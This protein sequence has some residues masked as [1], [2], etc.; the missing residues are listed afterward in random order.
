MIST[1]A[2]TDTLK[3]TQAIWAAAHQLGLPIA[4]WRLPNTQLVQG[5]VDLSGKP[6]QTIVDLEELPAGFVVSPF[7]NPDTRQSLF[8]HADILF[9]LEERYDSGGYA[10]T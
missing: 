6:Q 5:V 8:L 7:I 1:L 9:T 10:A 2:L 3:Y 4:L